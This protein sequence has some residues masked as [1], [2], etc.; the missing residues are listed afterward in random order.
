MRNALSL[1]CLVAFL[2]LASPAQAQLRSAVP[3]QQPAV[4]LFD[5]GATGF[6]LNTLFNPANFQMR[7]TFEMSMGSYGGYNS[8]LGMYTNTLAWQ[9]NDKLAARVDMSVA[10]SPFNNASQ[11]GSES[12]NTR[13]FLRNAEI[14]YRPS[15]NVQ[16]HFQV[17]QSPYG[18]YMGPYGRYSPYRAGYFY[19]GY[20]GP[21]SNLFWKDGAR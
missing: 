1:L 7:H 9:F 3:Q 12:N 13:V 5:S 2:G 15:E 4:R 21:S 16:L 14:A 10:Y 18:S 8:S 20:G 19:D 17:R 11:F 6:L